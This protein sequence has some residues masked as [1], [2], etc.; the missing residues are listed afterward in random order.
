MAGMLISEKTAIALENLMGMFFQ[1]NRILDRMSSQLSV[2]FVMPNTSEIVH[3]QFAHVMPLIGD[4]ISEYCDDRNY[5]VSYPETTRDY[6]EYN[7]LSDMF[8]KIL[9]YMIDIE[10]T[11]IECVDIAEDENDLMTK[12]FLEKFLYEEVRPYT[13]LAQN[14]VDYVQKNGD[15]PIRHMSMDSRINRFLGIESKN[16]DDD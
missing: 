9:D 11:V 2:K 8:N 16:E 14:F 5:A 13:K 4:K 10:G 1:A 7:N 15:E 12:H 3:K 6:T